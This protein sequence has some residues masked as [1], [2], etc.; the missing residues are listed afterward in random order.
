M[1]L[2]LICHDEHSVN[3][4]EVLRISVDNCN[5]WASKYINQMSTQSIPK[6]HRVSF[7]LDWEIHQSGWLK[8]LLKRRFFR[9]VKIVMVWA[10]GHGVWS[11]PGLCCAR[12]KAVGFLEADGFDHFGHETS[13][14]LSFWPSIFGALFG[15]FLGIREYCSG[16]CWTSQWAVTA[17]SNH[18]SPP[19]HIEQLPMP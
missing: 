1:P 15:Y 5:K 17:Q 11:F 16:N 6:C 9:Y 12:P 3:T 13:V 7:Y 14:E 18:L 4:L 19:F 8:P 2:F 10:F